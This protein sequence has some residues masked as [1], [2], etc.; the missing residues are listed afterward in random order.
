VARELETLL[1][2][3]A[4]PDGKY[5]DQVDALSCVAVYND[6]V[7]DEARRWGSSWGD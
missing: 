5:D 7:I 3:A 1:E 2:I 4:F 6:R